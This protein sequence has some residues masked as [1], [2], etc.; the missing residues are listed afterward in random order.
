MWPLMSQ[1]DRTVSSSHGEG[2]MSPEDHPGI[3][4]LFGSNS[5][6]AVLD[7]HGPEETTMRESK[8]TRLGSVADLFAGPVEL[9]ES[10]ISCD[11]D[12]HRTS[13]W[14]SPSETAERPKTQGRAQVEGT[15]TGRWARC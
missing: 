5:S 4:E 12:V 15:L 1:S 9:H 10:K 8:T 6:P 11:G 3:G 13:P 2:L 14:R 7:Q